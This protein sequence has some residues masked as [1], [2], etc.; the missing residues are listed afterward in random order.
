M[1]IFHTLPLAAALLAACATQPRAAGPPAAAAEPCQGRCVVLV[2]NPSARP[3]DVYFNGIADSAPQLLGTVNPRGTAHL[4]VP[5][6]D[7]GW[8]LLTVR[9]R[10]N[11]FVIDSR[12]VRLSLGRE[13]EFRIDMNRMR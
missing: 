12:R 7:A 5:V 9:E 2:D 1:R 3:L 4:V 11:G 13:A 8:V 6:S 10:P